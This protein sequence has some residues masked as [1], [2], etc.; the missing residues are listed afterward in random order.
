[1]GEVTEMS[2]SI[3]PVEVAERLEAAANHIEQYGWCRGAARKGDRCCSYG[4]ISEVTHAIRNQMA[5]SETMLDYLVRNQPDVDGD[6]GIIAMFDW[7]DR[8]RD[9]RKVVRHFRRA[10]RLVRQHQQPVVR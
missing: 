3:R 4:A 10:A 7:N 1:M 5:V 6:Q 9:R 2:R 8:Q